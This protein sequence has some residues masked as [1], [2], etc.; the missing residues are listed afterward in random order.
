MVKRNTPRFRGCP[1]IT[2]AFPSRRTPIG[3]WPERTLNLTA[4]TAPMVL[5]LERKPLSDAR[6]LETRRREHKL[7]ID[8]QREVE[9]GTLAAVLEHRERE[10]EGPRSFWCPSDDPCDRIEF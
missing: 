2:P 10:G 5:T 4:P 7:W 6:R 8:S 9:R 3:K 1:R